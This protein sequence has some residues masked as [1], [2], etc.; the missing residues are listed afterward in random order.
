MS[1]NCPIGA[2]IIGRNEG[3]RLRRCLA[4]LSGQFVRSIYVDS[5]SIDGSVAMAR[6]LGVDVVELDAATPFTAARARNAGFRYLC[7]ALPEMELVQFIDGDCEL[8][9]DWLDAAK[10]V[11]QRNTDA[12]VVC[13]RRRERSPGDSVYNRLCDLEWD[14][15][16]GEAESCG[17]D[18]L[19]R[20]VA[21][22]EAGGF[23]DELI[24]GEEPDLCHRL[25]KAGW[26]IYRLAR[27]MTLHDAAMSRFAQ[28]WQR[29]RR[30]G[31]A[32]AEALHRRGAEDRRLWRKVMSNLFWANPM[33]LPLWPLLWL[34]VTRHAGA[35]YA[36]FILLG[37]IPHVQGQ[38]QFWLNR[39]HLKKK[40]KLIEYK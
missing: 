11:M 37:K 40:G 17:G 2:V 16:V 14:T 5:G 13:G 31:Y 3:E 25:R 26:N 24:A 18:S 39:L 34:R 9:P 33:S 1:Q 38:M 36:S 20:V 19:M 30:S 22:E 8:H 27:E 6:S 7:D 28:W 10:A 32:S 23:A 12:A 21:L 29:N 35:L 15:T 4:S